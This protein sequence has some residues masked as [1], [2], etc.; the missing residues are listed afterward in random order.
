M[1]FPLNTVNND[2][3]Y[4]P[5][6]DG[7]RGYYS[8][9]KGGQSNIYMATLLDKE[10]K[11]LTLVS[12]ITQDS[13]IDENYYPL[14][15]C[16]IKKDTIILPDQRIIKSSGSFEM[17]DS[18][19]SSHY[20]IENDTVL[21]TDSI[22]FVPENTKIYVLDIETKYLDNSYG[23]NI[24][25]GNYLFV[26]N[27]RKNYKIYYE[28]EN[29][30][31]DTENILLT[32]DSSFRKIRYDAEMD[33]IIKGHVCK[34]KMTPFDQNSV[35][36]NK[37]TELEM[38]ILA[39]FLNLHKD[40]LVNISGYD[41]LTIKLDPN[42]Y[43]VQ[44]N[45]AEARKKA[46]TDYL[47]KKGV[48]KER[49]YTD[50]SA[51]MITGDVV[52]Y[53][54]YDEI[55]LAKAQRDKE[56]RN[57]MFDEA[58]SAA[59]IDEDDIMNQYGESEDDTDTV[60]V[61]D[62]LFEINKYETGKYE[63]NL[64]KLSEYIKNNED[65]IVEI[66]GHTD[67]QGPKKYNIALAQKRADFVKNDLLSR[68]VKREQIKIKNYSFSKPIAKNKTKQGKFYWKSLPYNRRTE[69]RVIEQGENEFLGINKILVPAQYKADAGPP[70]AEDMF[71]VSL[72][73]SSQKIK[74]SKF[75]PLRGVKEHENS[76][77]TYTYYLGGYKTEE[78]ALEKL[79]E[80]RKFYKDAFIFLKDF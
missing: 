11:I 17:G 22:Y 78:K 48:H 74:L 5:S 7:K 68:G 26:L 28:A 33:T 69:I 67:L 64:K 42:F 16:K 57:K 3:F 18:V 71:A 60:Y 61:C 12:G 46:C 2:V 58:Q 52:E 32:E 41:F 47:L 14:T 36:L 43:P 55:T 80:I 79:N 4:V 62:M 49:I 34:S 20:L 76:D 8:S 77:E 59:N 1:G 35:I 24:L 51:N 50:L 54:I 66:G 44:F 56:A 13:R 25:S 75:L 40:L 70:V 31:F 15:D 38:D 23:P 53:T 73:V 72:K 39:N 45:L 10:E 21:I 9:Q 63:D 6:A 19:M 27:K 37:T 30:I 65:A 29:H